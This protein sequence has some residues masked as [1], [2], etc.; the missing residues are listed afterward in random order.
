MIKLITPSKTIGIL[1]LCCAVLIT[2]VLAQDVP[3]RVS[4]GNAVLSRT[5]IAASS[6]NPGGL[7]TEASLR[8]SIATSTSVPL[9]TKATIS[10]EEVDN[11]NNI[12]YNVRNNGG[13]L[14]QDSVVEL[15]GLGRATNTF[16][17]I[18]PGDNGARGGSVQFRVVLRSVAN[19]SNN[20]T[21]AVM[22]E[23]PTT[24]TTG[25]MLTFQAATT[26][27]GS[28]PPECS[29]PPPAFLC[30]QYIPETNCPYTVEAPCLSSP[31][32]IDVAGN[33]F[34]LTDAANGVPFDIN[35]D[36]LKERLAWTAAD[37]DDAWLAL[38]R[39][40][41]G[42]IENGAE[43]FGNYSPQPRS[44]NRNGFLA[45]A[46]FDKPENGGNNDGVIN[47]QDEIFTSLR[48]WQDKNHS[49]ISEPAELHTLPELDVAEIELR[50]KESKRT[51]E[52][53][54]QFKY[55]AKVKDARGAKV[56]RWAW[57][58][59]LQYEIYRP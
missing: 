47:N 30:Y 6:T 44:A 21:P 9:N 41:T 33:G 1:C 36:G 31:I 13:I 10:L 58:V 48:L 38:D 14:S 26:G 12:N 27:G 54:N 11:P 16:F 15:E 56:G 37:S 52:H 23:P 18:T 2:V 39:N 3:R 24:F 43:L 42:K 57:D 35:G 25:L 53:G 20:P 34:D 46:E 7:P 59:F 4:I 5:T 50:Y 17:T 49:G 32:L 8:V 29:D 51:D 40:G 28:S 19:P 45:L 22:T 55:Q